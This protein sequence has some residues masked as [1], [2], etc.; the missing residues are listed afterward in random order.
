MPHNLCALCDDNPRP[1][2]VTFGAG[3]RELHVCQQHAEEI[4]LL[5][6]DIAMPGMNGFD[7]AAVSSL[8]KARVMALAAEL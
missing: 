4:G 2:T 8:S 3:K 7:F 5:M 1:A 6:T